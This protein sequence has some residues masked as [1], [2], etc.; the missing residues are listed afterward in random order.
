MAK[1]R[2]LK[3]GYDDDPAYE[4]VSELWIS[5]LRE[6]DTDRKSRYCIRCSGRLKK[7]SDYDVHKKCYDHNCDE[8][9]E[10]IYDTNTGKL[11]KSI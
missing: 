8:N 2:K 9:N 4:G 6:V 5:R 3:D 7:D 11:I 1:E 10:A